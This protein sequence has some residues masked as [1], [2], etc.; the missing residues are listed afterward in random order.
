MKFNEIKGTIKYLSVLFSIT[1]LMLIGCEYLFRAALLIK[2][3]FKEAGN[4]RNVEKVLQDLII[5]YDGKYSKDKIEEMTPLVQASLKFDSWI[6][7]S[8]ADHQ[9]KYS[10]VVNGKRRTVK[11]SLECNEPKEVWFFGGSTTFGVGVPW[12]STIPSKFVEV[13]DKAGLCFNVSNFGVPYHYSFQEVTYLTSEIAKGNI[14]KPD[15]A[16]FVDGLNDFLFSGVSIRK[17]SAF[18]LA[19]KEII[20]DTRD[21]WLHINQLIKGTSLG[22]IYSFPFV[23]NSKLIKYIKYKI[24]VKKTPKLDAN[25]NKIS[26]S[27]SGTDITK[28]TDEQLKNVPS[29]IKAKAVADSMKNTRKFLSRVCKIYSIKC[30]QFLQPVPMVDYEPLFNETLT[31]TRFTKYE[32][33]Q[34]FMDGYKIV[35]DDIKNDNYQNLSTYDLSPL[36][37]KYKD[38][39]PYVDSTH[40]SP[41]ASRLISENIFEVIEKDISK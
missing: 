10:E 5:A 28:Y 22:D 11:S 30:Y 34:F 38:G 40:Y 36:F 21:P 32:V 16:I 23:F 19:L 4:T 7:L 17:E 12:F 3:S 6:V 1:L 33:K 37:L 31:D 8:N 9:N 26:L 2:K 41:R 20:S 29:E 13:S 15:V 39:I 18:A 35:K 24:S 14:K 25:S 27:Y